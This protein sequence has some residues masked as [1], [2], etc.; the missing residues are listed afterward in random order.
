M[1]GRWR[2]AG[3]DA[4]RSTTGRRTGRDALADELGARVVATRRPRP[5]RPPTSS[6]T[7]VADDAAVD[8][9]LRRAGRRPRRA[10]GR[11][12]SLVDMSTVPPAAIR[13]LACAGHARA[14]R[15]AS[16]TRRCRAASALAEAGQ[17]TIMVG[18]DAADLERARP[19]LEPL[20]KRVFHLG[21]LGHRRGDE[22]RRQHGDLRA[23]Q[24]PSPRGSC[25]PSAAGIDRAL[26]Y[27]VLAASAVGAPYVGY[28]RAAF[29]DPEGTPGRVLARARGEGPAADRRA[30]RRRSGVADARRPPSTSTSSAPR[31]AGRRG[32]RLLDRRAVT[33][34]RRAGA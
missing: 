25:S 2:A 26:A 18:G 22:A 10:S 9:G 7:M 1:A 29:L 15:R 16:S 34:A 28:K 21:P 23:Q 6:I 30:R 14:G 5:P 24:A 17:L 27:D 20:A 12:R 19:V 3:F 32:R 13:S 33:C 31:P 4:R 11:A 8:A